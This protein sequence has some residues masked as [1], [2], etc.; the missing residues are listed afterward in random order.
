MEKV[1]K[2]KEK[3]TV[4][5]SDVKREKSGLLKDEVYDESHSKAQKHSVPQSHAQIRHRHH[6]DSGDE[7]PPPKDDDTCTSRK[8]SS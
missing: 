7:G 3:E 8:K 4:P 6:K 5:E 2:D 1:K